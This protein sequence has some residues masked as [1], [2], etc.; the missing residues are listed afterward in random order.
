V[1]IVNDA[2]ELNAYPFRESFFREVWQDLEFTGHD[3]SRTNFNRS[4][5]TRVRFAG[6]RLVESFACWADFVDCDFSGAD[7]TGCDMRASLFRGC[8]FD[9]AILRGADLRRSSFEGCS[10]VGA[11]MTGAIA[12]DYE[13]MGYLFDKLTEAQLATMSVHADPGPEP[14]GG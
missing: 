8:R 13:T 6:C 3:H 7:L 12:D 14:P 1:A 4:G 11:D 9:G 10:F 5:W 2:E